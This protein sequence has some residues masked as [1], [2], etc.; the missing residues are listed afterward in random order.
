MPRDEFIKVGLRQIIGHSS[1]RKDLS[2]I[3]CLTEVNEDS[4]GLF[5]SI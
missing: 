3:L 2:F 4:K 5:L 1:I